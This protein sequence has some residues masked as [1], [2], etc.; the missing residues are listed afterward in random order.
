M[1]GLCNLTDNPITVK[2]NSNFG[3]FVCISKKHKVF[4]INNMAGKISVTNQ[5]NNT[6]VLGCDKINDIIPKSTG[7]DPSEGETEQLQT[8]L[9]DFADVFVNKDGML[10]NCDLLKHEIKVPT[11]HCP[12]RQRPYKMGANKRKS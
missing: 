7:Y 11:D 2:K 6:R 5:Y 3:K 8:L 4:N 1:H 9:E 10:G 12:I